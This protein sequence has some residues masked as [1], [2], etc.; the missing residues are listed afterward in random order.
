MQEYETAH[1]T[2]ARAVREQMERPVL[3]VGDLVI[4][5]VFAVMFSIIAALAM[6]VY[7]PV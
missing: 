1:E 2:L 7:V 6:A 5:A 3:F 4:A